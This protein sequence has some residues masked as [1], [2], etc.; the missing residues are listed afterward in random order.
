MVLPRTSYFRCETAWV[1]N[2]VDYWVGT[3]VR[4]D[5]LPVSRV[6]RAVESSET[7]VPLYQ[8]AQRHMSSLELGTFMQISE[9]E[10]LERKF[11][12]KIDEVTNKL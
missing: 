4:R 12:P 8:S 6:E 3:N 5:M 9:N 10:V 2:H 11:G 7:F 1:R